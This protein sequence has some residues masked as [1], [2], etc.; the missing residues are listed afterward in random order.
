M[1]SPPQIL[2]LDLSL[3]GTGWCR[4]GETGRIRTSL[5]GMERIDLITGT[6]KALLDDVDLAVVEGYSF[7]SQGRSVCQIGE[8]GG[9]VRLMLYRLGVRYVDVPPSTLKKYAAGRGN[10]GKDEMIAAAIRR[11]GF[12]GTS[13]DEADAFLLWCMARHA[14]GEPVADVPQR[15]LAALDVVTWPS[16]EDAS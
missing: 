2:A 3:Q 9:C 13:N 16:L 12:E 1:T 8:L 15:Q 4:D 11:F 14:Y 7:G 6:V 5:R 10:C